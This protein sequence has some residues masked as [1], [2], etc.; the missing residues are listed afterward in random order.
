MHLHG[1]DFVL[2]AQGN[3][4][5]QLPSAVL[6]FDNPPRRDTALVASGG[7]IVMAFKADNPGSWVFHCHIPWHASNGL[8]VQILERQSDFATMMTDE[9]LNRTRQICGNW[10][11]WY[12]NPANR[13]DPDAPF[14]EDSGI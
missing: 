13:W 12:N 2:L 4:T 6:N 3:D 7:Y 8:A 9:R 14:Q 5:D 11:D 1:H 10:T